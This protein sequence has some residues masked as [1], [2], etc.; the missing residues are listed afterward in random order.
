MRGFDLFSKKLYI[1]TVY[2]SVRI[3]LV[4]LDQN[5]YRVVP[6]TYIYRTVRQNPFSQQNPDSAF[7]KYIYQYGTIDSRKN[8]KDCYV[9]WTSG[10]FE[11]YTSRSQSTSQVK[12]S[13]VKSSQVKSSHPE[14]KYDCMGIYVRLFCTGVGWSDLIR[15]VGSLLL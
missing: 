8:R 11:V 4:R 10:F 12:S 7:Q 2:R 6:G 5:L 15:A 3:H 13:Q 1:T 9:N 14:V